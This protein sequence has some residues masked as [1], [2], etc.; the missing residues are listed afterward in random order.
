MDQE[1]KQ[2]IIEI[3]TAVAKTAVTEAANDVLAKMREFHLDDMKVLDE[4]MDIGF[5]RVDERF[6]AV[7]A[8][9]DKVETR[10][11]SVEIKVVNLEQRFDGLEQRFDG[12]EQRFERVES[13]LTTLL[14]E[15]KEE[16][17]EVRALKQQVTDLTARVQFLEN[18]LLHA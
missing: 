13:A 6:D 1:T 5:A 11:D 4:R 18:K 8:R 9:L 12:L 2:E 7:E 17:A 10:L 14:Q 15:F 16:R 3:A